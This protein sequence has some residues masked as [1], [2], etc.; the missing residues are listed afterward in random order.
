LSNFVLWKTVKTFALKLV[1]PMDSLFRI[2]IV[3]IICGSMTRKR[4]HHSQLKCRSFTT[5]IG[6]LRLYFNR[7]VNPQLL[8]N[9]QQLKGNRQLRFPALSKLHHPLMLWGL[10]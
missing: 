7:T 6:F 5:F 10:P 3:Q 1:R 8:M 2:N 9:H 4:Y